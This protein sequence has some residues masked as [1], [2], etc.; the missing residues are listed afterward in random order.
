MLV[1]QHYKIARK[2]TSKL[3]REEVSVEVRE[4]SLS[5]SNST[6]MAELSPT[7]DIHNNDVNELKLCL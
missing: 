2:I 5:F 1:I 7:V 4:P 3:R 6:T